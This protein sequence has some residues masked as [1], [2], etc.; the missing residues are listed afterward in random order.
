MTDKPLALDDRLDRD[1]EIRYKILLQYI[2]AC[3]LAQSGPGDLR[4]IL[5]AEE[6]YCA[7]GGGRADLSSGVNSIQRGK[8]DLHHDQV[9]LEFSRFLNRF[10]SI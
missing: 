10:Q 3:S 9:R 2:P 8:A 6:Q 1:G 4:I 5:S 7:F